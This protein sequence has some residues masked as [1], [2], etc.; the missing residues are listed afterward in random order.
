MFSL[1]VLSH[2]TSVFPD[3]INRDECAIP[4]VDCHSGNIET[5]HGG[6]R[7]ITKLDNGAGPFYVSG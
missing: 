1:D 7:F 2:R 5:S 4:T 6:Y 3:Y